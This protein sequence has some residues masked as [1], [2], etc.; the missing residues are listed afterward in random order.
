MEGLLTAEEKEKE[1]EEA[2]MAKLVGKVFAEKRERVR[3]LE[4]TQLEVRGEGPTHQ[5]LSYVPNVYR[6]LHPLNSFELIGLSLQ[7]KSNFLNLSSE[8]QTKCRR[9]RHL[10]NLIEMDPVRWTAGRWPLVV[11]VHQS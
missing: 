10:S 4:D 6:K 1:E 7:V 11:G 2:V 8:R 3:R 5:L 9:T